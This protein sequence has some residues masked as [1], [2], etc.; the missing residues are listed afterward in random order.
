MENDLF[1]TSNVT[2]IFI[3][4]HMHFTYMHIFL[5]WATRLQVM[6]FSLFSAIIFSEQAPIVS[7]EEVE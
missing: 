2:D 6:K 5:R 3:Y 4:L 1:A 7:N